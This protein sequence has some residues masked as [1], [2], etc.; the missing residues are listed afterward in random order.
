M[1]RA[2][3]GDVTLKNIKCAYNE[4]DSYPV[5]KIRVEKRVVHDGNDQGSSVH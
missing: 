2:P 5:P 3:C 1:H 4:S